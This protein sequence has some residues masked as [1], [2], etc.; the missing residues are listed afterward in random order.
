MCI[1]VWL[2]K[3][4]SPTM[5]YV[6]SLVLFSVDNPNSN[7]CYT[8]C[9]SPMSVEFH[10]IHIFNVNATMRTARGGHEVQVVGIATSSEPIPYK[11]PLDTPYTL[12]M[13]GGFNFIPCEKL[14]KPQ[15]EYHESL[16][17]HQIRYQSA[18]VLFNQL[19]DSY[20]SLFYSSFL[21]SLLSF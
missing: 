9:P 10:I 4:A 1:R 20:F 8:P 18:F 6:P 13:V 15:L 5:F 21:P 7:C 16:G 3:P 2:K 11:F 19:G 17:L 12:G 14:D